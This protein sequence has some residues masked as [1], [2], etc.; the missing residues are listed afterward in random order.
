MLVV[1]IGCGM[2]DELANFRGLLEQAIKRLDSE[3]DDWQ[4]IVLGIRD[5]LPDEVKDA[6]RNEVQTLTDRCIA[7]SGV[8]FRANVDFLARRAKFGLQRVLALVN[9]E[10]PEPLTP[11]FAQVTPDILDINAD[12]ASRMSVVLTGWDLDAKDSQGEPVA[13]A[14]LDGDSKML[15]KIPDAR[16]G[17]ATH[18]QLTLNV[19]GPEFEALLWRLKPRKVVAVWNG[20]YGY[21]GDVS[22]LVISDWI[23]KRKTVEWGGSE[24]SYTPPHVVGDKEFWANDKHP[25]HIDLLAHSRVVDAKTIQVCVGM[26]AREDRS[27]WTEASGTGD[28]QIAYTAPEGWQIES[29][30]PGPGTSVGHVDI[31]DRQERDVGM[32]AGEIARNFHVWGD[33]DGDDAGA[34]TRVIA[35][36][37]D[38]IIELVQASPGR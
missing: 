28:W 24:I 33:K 17:R 32:A 18:Y 16:I 1:C 34:H 2:Q 27:D 14:L 9:G 7:K 5:K 29:I 30:I 13:F 25:I 3:Q 37:A 10:E 35:S 31:G 19:S 12:P 36:F 20:E 15:E 6:I 38:L 22:E 26:H 8:E 21:Q 23:P 11:Y 4:R